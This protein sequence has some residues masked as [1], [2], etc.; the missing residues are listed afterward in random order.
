MKTLCAVLA[1]T[2]AAAIVAVPAEAAKKRTR[3]P[4]PHATAVQPDPYTVVD[5]DG[6]VLG[7]DPDPFIRLMIRREGKIRDQNSR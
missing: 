3:A 2:A 6:E 7:R 5:Y 1:F 4:T